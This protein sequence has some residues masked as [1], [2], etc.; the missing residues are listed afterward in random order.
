MQGNRECST[1]DTPEADFIKGAC[2][3]AVARLLDQFRVLR[4]DAAKEGLDPETPVRLAAEATETVG[5][6]WRT[7]WHTGWPFD[8]CPKSYASESRMSNPLW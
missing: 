2:T 6:M 1:Q 7:V 4:A 3:H 5:E 8:P